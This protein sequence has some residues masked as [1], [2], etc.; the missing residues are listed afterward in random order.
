MF[1][2]AVSLAE[3][4]SDRRDGSVSVLRLVRCA[5]AEG[6]GSAAVG[7][8]A[9][10]SCLLFSFFFIPF[11]I[12]VA[13]I[14]GGVMFLMIACH[15][16]GPKWKRRGSALLLTLSAA[17]ILLI[18]GCA[19]LSFM[20]RD[21]R[22]SGYQERSERAWCL[23][24]SGLEYYCSYGCGGAALSAS[25]KAIDPPRVL[26]RVYVPAAN[27]NQYFELA[28]MGQ[29][30]LLSRGVDAGTLSSNRRQELLITRSLVIKAQKVED[31]YDA[32]LSF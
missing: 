15:G 9:A 24:L 11:I 10:L 30:N 14:G 6:Y 23:A 8:D 19:Y 1:R 17:V 32:S 16:Y 28:D 29:G 21:N 5:D 20:E 25:S 18:L 26:V 22:F 3:C 7:I 4:L 27:P 31:A 2:Q 13:K 12:L